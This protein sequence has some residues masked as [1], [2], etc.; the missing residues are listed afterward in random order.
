MGN[1]DRCKLM[2]GSIFSY[3]TYSTDIIQTQILKHVKS[4]N[5]GFE[6]KTLQRCEL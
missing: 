4:G 1:T 5:I 6:D 2:H 3:C